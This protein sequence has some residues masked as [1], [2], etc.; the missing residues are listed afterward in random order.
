MIRTFWLGRTEKA[1]EII[2]IIGTPLLLISGA[3]LKATPSDF[4]KWG[5]IKH[6]VE[7]NQQNAFIII[8][9]LT[10]VVG[11][12]S[13][14]KKRLGN[15]NNWNTIT[16]LLEKYKKAI[17][18][19]NQDNKDIANDPEH[20]HRITLY[21][22]ARWRWG[23]CLYPWQGWMIPVARTGHT[24]H[25]FRIPRF[26]VFPSDPDKAEGVAG[27]T[28]VRRRT[29]PV[30]NLPEINEQSS[31]IDIENYAVKGF[32]NKQWIEKRKKKN[33]CFIRSMIG[34][35]VEV[36]NKTWGVMVID[37]RRPEGI[38][39]ESVLATAQFTTM[40]EVLGKLLEN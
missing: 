26:R 3:M 21:K 1:F 25:S 2:Q 35:P 22:F 8:P 12:V 9:L 16:Y 37:S 13:F 32:V 10:I 33:N 39:N 40:A 14:L 19:N 29:V 27:Q 11:T 20:H 28:Y 17:F 18:E 24:T 23:I 5:F 7:L 6:L 31:D 36:K 38:S 15:A 34:I 30:E 4:E